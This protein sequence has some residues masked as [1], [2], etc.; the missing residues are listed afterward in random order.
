MSMELH[1]FFCGQLPAK[2][3]LTRAMKELGFPLAIAPAKGALERQNGFMPMRLGRDETGVEF[4]IFDGRAAIEDLAGSEDVDPRL[5]RSAN[6]RWSGDETEMLCAL[7]AA[8]AL[9]KLV[10]GVVFDPQD[11][12]L[13]TVAEAIGVAHENLKERVKAAARRMGTT[14]ADIKRYLKPLLRQ[15]SD[16][17]LIGRRLLIRPVRHLLRGALFDRTSDKYCFR[18]WRYINPLY[19]YAHSVGYGGYVHTQHPHVW[20]SHFE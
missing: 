11:G 12:R 19:G 18:L 10:D 13:L 3:A 17:V 14:P 2:T 6:F 7:G 15:R 20:E 1:V 9:A 5:D 4:D 16:L 8:A